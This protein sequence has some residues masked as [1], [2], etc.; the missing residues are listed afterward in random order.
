MLAAIRSFS[1][2]WVAAVI[3]G[4][5]I[6]SFAVFGISDV[7]RGNIQGDSVV[8]AGD[9]TVAPAEFKRFFDNYKQNVEQQMGRPV[10]TEELAA[11]GIDSRILE[12]VATREGFAEFLHQAG[13]VPSD[14]L[15]AE[16]LHQI[17]AFFGQVSG[18]FEKAAYEQALA[19]NE[20]TPTLFERSV[21][22]DIAEQHLAS[23][24]RSGLEAPRA[25]TALAAIFGLETR[26]VSYVTI[27]P[28]A[29]AQPAPPTDA[30]LQAFMKEN[31]AML[32]RPEMRILTVA[33]FSPAAVAPT[34]AIDEAAVKK[35]FEF[36]KDTLSKP[37]VRSFV[38]IPVKDQAAAQKAVQRLGSG[39]APVAVAKSL[40]VDAI[41]YVDKPLT[42]VA[43]PKI[44][45]AAFQA[46]T[47]QVSTV[48]GGL[49]LAV[50]KVTS[51]TPGRAVTLEEIRPQLEAEVRKDA[52]TEK[53]YAMSQTYDTAH[54]GGASLAES[55]K[56]A[57]APVATFGPITAEGVNA[58]RQ[59]TPGLN[60]NLLKAAFGLPEGGESD[61]TEAG[62][63]D[64]FAVRV[65]KILP[66]AMP[67]LNEI[68][69]ELA[70]VWMFRELE[71]RLQ[72]RADEMAA[73]ATK[74]EA[75]SKL[76][77]V[78]QLTAI[79]RAS[80]GQRQGV[81]PDML[82]KLFAAKA[83][84]VFTARN[85]R[86]GMLVAKVDKV[87][88]GDAQALARTVAMVRPQMTQQAF[89]DIGVATRNAA[90]KDVKVLIAP[91]SARMAIGLEPIEPAKG[92]KS[93]SEAKK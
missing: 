43:D 81:S 6:V 73:R 55:A 85:V 35:Q 34:V 54:Q 16:Q 47:G 44:G 22:D 86:V 88:A 7:F 59:P 11:N 25:Y 61:L 8:K 72:A 93:K 18:R 19:R 62:N 92:G 2:S 87:H 21:R 26:D 38:Q 29:V 52:A 82:N 56:A 83:G 79:D 53:V 89:T 70:Q 76:G 90:R 36:R 27:D 67:P 46:Q 77:S 42:A 37:E 57:G 91:N 28:T 13:V 49:G 64:Y 41:T 68:R 74:G 20:L 12:E 39:E 1:K 60:E 71:K 10:T 9:R 78:T 80:A 84:D 17:P 3:I 14:K 63:G 4:L 32:T 30:Q 31:A 75:M 66:A 45:Q 5:I 50:I 48:Q 51:V 15:V 65:E 33:V 23:A 24:M 40:G 58:N 69:N